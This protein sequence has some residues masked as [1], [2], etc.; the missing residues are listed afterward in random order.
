[1]CT[2]PIFECPQISQNF[3][4]G[5][6]LQ[7][8]MH[9]VLLGL[10]LANQSACC[11]AP[12]SEGTFSQHGRAVIRTLHLPL[13]KAELILGLCALPEET[14]AAQLIQALLG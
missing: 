9:A 13:H 3:L 12:G 10:S 7:S 5:L 2:C 8:A 6:T 4:W 11:C 14:R 1:M